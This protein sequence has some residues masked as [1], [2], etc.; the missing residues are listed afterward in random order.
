MKRL[1][2]LLA[3][4]LGLLSFAAVRE[5]TVRCEQG[6]L[7]LEG[8]GCLLLNGG[9]CLALNGEQCH[10]AAGDIRVPVP[11]WLPIMFR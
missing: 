7:L 10:I 3:L 5:V 4:F 6:Y 2:L 1:A 11:P 8:G 9:G